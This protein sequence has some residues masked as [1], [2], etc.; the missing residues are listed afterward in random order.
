MIPEL[1][2]HFFYG[3]FCR[4]WVRSFKLS[5]TEAKEQTE[6]FL[7][8]NPGSITSFGA[9]GDGEIYLLNLAGDVFR[10]EA[11]RAEDEAP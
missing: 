10:I 3:D 5:G 7:Q 8:M 1:A 4:G 11:I 9:G 6:W 2:G